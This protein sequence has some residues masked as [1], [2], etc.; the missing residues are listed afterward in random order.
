MSPKTTRT[1]VHKNDRGQY[2]VTIPKGVGDY[3]DLD[4]AELEWRRG[5]ATNKIELVIHD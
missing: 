5:S 4:G 3:H 2:Q 1:K